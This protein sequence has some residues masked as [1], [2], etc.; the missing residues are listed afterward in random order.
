[1]KKLILPCLAL[2]FTFSVSALD[3]SIGGGFDYLFYEDGLRFTKKNTQPASLLNNFH[4]V[5]FMGFVDFQH[6]QLDFGYYGTASGSF[7]PNNWS[8]VADTNISFENLNLS[9]VS[10][11]ISGKYPIMMDTVRLSFQVGL[12][13]RFAVN[14]FIA[15]ERYYN[16]F[17]LDPRK[18]YDHFWLEGAISVDIFMLRQLFAR[19]QFSLGG[20]LGFDYWDSQKKY[21]NSSIADISYTTVGVRLFL[22]LGYQFKLGDTKGS[23]TG[24]R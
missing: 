4:N 7:E 21:F 5:G 1:M 18:D 24:R 2:F 16:V 9:L 20:A 12:A 17:A 3:I 19:F 22:G 10:I 8:D 11:G 6:I 13:Y 15:Q 14:D 23:G